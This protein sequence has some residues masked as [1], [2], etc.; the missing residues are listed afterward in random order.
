M[1]KVRPLAV[2]GCYYFSVQYQKRT[3]A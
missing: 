3:T 1:E 2:L